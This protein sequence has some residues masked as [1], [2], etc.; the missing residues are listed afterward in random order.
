MSIQANINVANWIKAEIK[1]VESKP[2][3]YPHLDIQRFLGGPKKGLD[4]R[5][6]KSNTAPW[7]K[8]EMDGREATPV[9]TPLSS[10]ESNPL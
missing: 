1:E 3:K 6:E 7:N 10:D 4:H 9:G 5:Q 8:E 2:R